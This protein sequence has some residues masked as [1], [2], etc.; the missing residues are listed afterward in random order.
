MRDHALDRHPFLALP[1]LAL[2]AT[3]LLVL[4]PSRTAAQ[5][6]ME[7]HVGL[8]TSGEEHVHEGMQTSD[9]GYIGIGHVSETSGS[10]LDMLIIKTDADGNQEWQRRVGT[11]GQMD[12]GIAI[13]E[14]AS[15]YVAGGGL[16]ADGAQ[17]R[18]LVGLDL[19]GNV[20]WQR[21][22]AG[23]G[24]AAVRG[25]EALAN[26]DIVATGYT[27]SGEDG[28]VFLAEGSAFL[29]KTDASGNEIWNRTLAGMQGTKVRE[30][31][32]GGLAILSAD[33]VFEG[34]QDVL[35]AKLIRTDSAG[36]TTWSATYG[37]SNHID[38]FD[39][40]LTSD[41]GFAIAGH[42]PGYNTQNWDCILFRIDSDGNETWHRIFGQPRGYN[43]SWIHDECYGVRQT[44]DGGFVMV[45][46]SG[47]EYAYSASGHPAGPSD[48]WKSYVIVTDGAGNTVYEEVFGDGPGQGNNAA[49]YLALTDDGCYMVFND[50]DSATPPAPNN[51]GFMKICGGCSNCGPC[52]DGNV[53]EGEQC[54]DGNQINCDGCDNDC[55]NSTTCGNGFVCGA[56]D[57]DD[58]NT[59]DGDCCSATCSFET[60]GSACD[61][62]VAC[63]NPDVCD[64]AGACTGD[65][66]PATGCF[67]AGSGK[68]DIRN[69]AGG[70]KDS[71]SWDWKKG[72]QV[73]FA[74]FGDPVAGGTNYSVCI[75]DLDS[76][77]DRVAAS[78]E[79]PAGGECWGRSCWI[80]KGEKR[81]AYKDKGLT[82]DGIQQLQLKPGRAGKAK[83]KLKA[84]GELIPMPSLPIT[85]TTTLQVQLHNS[86]GMCWSAS[87]DV[88]ESG[89]EAE[90]F[91]SKY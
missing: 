56:E 18:A 14:T 80:S 45:G 9:G 74:D 7:W 20:I 36:N 88:S 16:H 10:R 72:P 57:C 89:N 61:D 60:L 64:G 58:G 42:T 73:D 85:D 46:G 79:A 4:A 87:F 53:D 55:T 27:N 5:L 40:D 43:A 48:E 22:Y 34:G 77:V 17:R 35:N 67:E 70:E 62:G 47:D 25:V 44:A 39:F 54:D 1:P 13:T 69:Y 78:L 21:T 86:A 71:I 82:S 50:T 41:G 28:F 32:G 2:L 90:R 29:M 11:S 63:T 33:W 65:Q 76:G 66:T 51:F 75:Y 31:T 37:G 68:I 30:E 59:V 84:K 15:G 52:G 83:L 81:V 23:G 12:I 6:V 49:E 8:G 91:S 3:A 19:S 26:G 38:P 24:A